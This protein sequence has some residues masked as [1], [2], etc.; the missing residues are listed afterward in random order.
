MELDWE[1]VSYPN[2]ESCQGN[3]E[4]LNRISTGKVFKMRPGGGREGGGLERTNS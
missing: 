4:R 2:F 3:S 1:A